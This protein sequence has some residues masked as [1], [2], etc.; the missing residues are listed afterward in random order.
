MILDDDGYSFLVMGSKYLEY[1]S[2][3]RIARY[4]NE[5]SKKLNHVS[6]FS[7]TWF[8]Y[9]LNTT[10][11]DT[12]HMSRGTCT[13]HFLSDVCCQFS[14][15]LLFAH[16]TDYPLY[17]LGNPPLMLV[18]QMFVHTRPW[19]MTNCPPPTPNS[20][21]LLP[22]TV[23]YSSRYMSPKMTSQHQVHSLIQE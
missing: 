21:P 7:H 10:S 17:L 8:I 9:N 23:P 18:V 13:S 20:P 1:I 12:I 16:I 2:S 6:C 15:S 11:I 14:H 5:G 3:I 22:L 19:L 4:H